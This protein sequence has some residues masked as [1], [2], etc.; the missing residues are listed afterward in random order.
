MNDDMKLQEKIQQKMMAPVWMRMEEDVILPVGDT[1]SKITV[2]LIWMQV[3]AHIL[4]N[5]S[6]TPKS[7]YYSLTD[8]T[9]SQ[10]WH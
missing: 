4:F 6:P 2:S 8:A 3:Q 10:I 5:I 9:R 7:I 1:I